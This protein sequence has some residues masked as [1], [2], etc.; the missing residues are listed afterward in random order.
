[1]RYGSILWF[2]L[3]AFAAAPLAAQDIVEE[4][5]EHVA[6]ASPMTDPAVSHG[7]T[8]VAL[9]PSNP[10]AIASYGPFRVLDSERA[11]MTGVTDGRT[12]AQLAAMLRDYPGITVLELVDC[13]GT[14]DSDANL[15][16]GRMVR[17]RGIATHVPAGG[18]VGSGA[19]ELFLAGARR[20]ADPSAQFAVHSWEDDRGLEQ[21]EY[22]PD[23]SENRDFLDYY[24]AMGMSK[25]QAR[26]FYDMTNSVPF[27]HAR[28]LTPN[29][30][31]LWVRLDR[32]V[33]SGR[34]A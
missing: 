28:W 32:T 3:L 25:E 24:Q 6:V 4:I 27:D 15:R 22:S 11:A 8:E 2:P 12:P 9:P 16:L 29:D 31:E 18:F 17:A 20:S 26:A 30:L 23:A 14:E 21:S 33:E 34:G 10:R 7:S 19:V 1:M 13:P 5:V